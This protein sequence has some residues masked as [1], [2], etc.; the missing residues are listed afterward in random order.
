MVKL[1]STFSISLALSLLC[2]RDILAQNTYNPIAL[3]YVPNMGQFYDSRCKPRPDILY[4]ADNGATTIFLKENGLSFVIN[5]LER[6]PK[7]EPGYKD[8]D[9]PGFELIEAHH[10]WL[11]L[12][13]FPLQNCRIDLDFE[14]A[15]KPATET[16][17]PTPGYRNYYNPVCP[18]GITKVKSFQQVVYKNIYPNV[19]LLFKGTSKQ[20]FEYDIIV[21]PGGNVN[22][23][24]MK[25]SGMS[26]MEIDSGRLV[27]INNARVLKG[28]IPKIYQYIGNE[29]KA[30]AGSYIWAGKGT[31][32]TV[33][34]NV[35][36]Y[37]KKYPLIIDPW[38][39]TYC[40]GSSDDESY[41]CAIDNYGF[42]LAGGITNSNNFPV[43]KGAFQATLG[44]STDGFI[45]KLD[46]KGQRVWATYYGGSAADGVYGIITDANNN[47]IIT[48][49]TS[50][51]N[52]P[53]SLGCFQST[54]GGLEDA[55]AV[56]FDPNGVRQWGTFLGGIGN[57]EGTAINV[58]LN[59]N[60]VVTGGTASSD[61]PVSNNAYQH[62]YT[63]SSGSCKHL[64]IGD[65]MGG[66]AFLTKFDPNGN[67]LW[68][69]YLGGSG[70]DA[71][72]GVACDANGNV[73]IGGTT[74]STDFPIS[75]NAFQ[76]QPDDG[77]ITEFDS[78]GYLL[79]STYYGAWIGGCA[80][81][82]S[83]NVI[84]G[85]YSK[86][87][88]T[89][90]GVYQTSFTTGFGFAAKF[91]S[92]GNRIWATFNNSDI[93][94][95]GDYAVAVDA[96]NNVYL[97]DDE[98]P[99]QNIGPACGFQPHY[100]N[101]R[102]C[103]YVVKL[104]SL[105]RYA[106]STYLCGTVYDEHEY[107]AANLAVKGGRMAIAGYTSGGIP[108]TP[109]AFQTTFPGSAYSP[110]V[111]NVCSFSCGDTTPPNLN[112]NSIIIKSDT[113]L[114]YYS[115]TSHAVASCD[116]NG[117]TFNWYFPGGTPA[118]ATGPIISGVL[119][120]STGT[121]TVKLVYN[122]CTTD[123]FSQSF[124]VNTSFHDSIAIQNPQ[125]C[126]QKGSA[127]ALPSGGIPPY[128]YWWSNG[129][130]TASVTGLGSGSYRCAITAA[131]GCTD[132]TLFTIYSPRSPA[133]ITKPKY[134]TGVCNGKGVQLLAT[135]GTNFRWSPKGSLSCNVC[136]N[137]VATPTITTDYTVTGTDSVGC[138]D[139]AFIEVLVD[140]IPYFK[141]TAT[142]VT[143]GGYTLLQ[144]PNYANITWRWSPGKN[145]SDSLSNE[146]EATPQDTTTY[147]L[148]AYNS[149]CSWLSTV[150]VSPVNNSFPLMVT[151][152]PDTV[153]QG[154]VIQLNATSPHHIVSYS[155]VPSGGLSCNSCANPT[156][157]TSELYLQSNTYTVA[158]AAKD[159]VG[160]EVKDTLQLFI[161]QG[162]IYEN[163]IL[164]CLDSTITLKIHSDSTY[165]WSNGDTT[166]SIT[167]TPRNS[168]YLDVIIDSIGCSDTINYFIIVDAGPQVVLTAAKDTICSG[169]STVIVGLSNDVSE[170]RWSPSNT[171]SC[172][173]CNN[174][175]AT[176]NT[177]TAYTVLAYDQYGCLTKDSITLHIVP[178]NTDTVH[179]TICEATPEPI[180]ITDGNIY[181][182]STGA[183][184]SSINIDLTRDSIFYVSVT[185]NGG[186]SDTTF[187][188]VHPE[189][190]E[191]GLSASPDS[192]C[193]GKDVNL[194]ATGA[195]VVGWTWK[196]FNLLNCY[197][198]PDPSA[199]E[200]L[201]TTDFVVTGTDSLGC[202][203]SDSV[204]V[205]II[206]LPN[207]NVTASSYHIC[208][209]DSVLL[210]A[211]GG[212]AYIWNTGQ[213]T[214]AVWFKPDKD[215]I[216]GVRVLVG[217]CADSIL[218]EV[219]VYPP[220]PMTL[221]I[222]SD[223][224]CPGQSALL[225][226]GGGSSYHWS[227]GDTTS[228]ITVSPALSATYTVQIN[229]GECTEDTIASVI[230]I[231]L[232]PVNI[233]AP[234]SI[235]IGAT[236]TLN[237]SGWLTYLWS[238]NATSSSIMVN[239]VNTTTYTVT[240][241]FSRCSKD[242]VIT[243]YVK[244]VNGAISYDSVICP[245]SVVH[246][247]ALGGST[248][249]WSTGSIA[250]NIAIPGNSNKDT[251]FYVV[252]TNQGCA[253]TV[254]GEVHYSNVILIHVCCDTII[255][256]GTSAYLT[257]FG[258]TYYSW[259]PV[260][261][262]NCDTCSSVIANPDVTT[263]YSVT[264]SDTNGCIGV[265]EVTVTV[266]AP[267]NNFIIPNV[268]TPNGDGINDDF[269]IKASETKDYTII[270]YDRWGKTMFTNN[271]PD[272]YWTGANP[273]GDNAPDGVYFYII[274]YTCS[275]KGYSK[276]GFVQIIR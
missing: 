31:N 108:T 8:D 116:S 253:D 120:H 232:P 109:G 247:T 272:I 233:N 68:S 200:L 1:H 34:F 46:S 132:T 249:L 69:T 106:C 181:L 202:K 86:D 263:T 15:L 149:F 115:F 151:A 103:L 157:T 184:S 56:K 114:G 191:V 80:I 134:D 57:D 37:D 167:I 168:E 25:F 90:P 243:I 65:A 29:E 244:A 47:V 74:T 128:T 262:L 38:F 117:A 62:V 67:L 197:Y 79:W 137:P 257:A 189:R 183:T 231:P 138:P 76:S 18:D 155:W 43:S 258:A 126:N 175:I 145:L 201:S 28:H 21:N 105:G 176:V 190:P 33:K 119:Y 216:F 276:K 235:C 125:N 130:T 223:S 153:C 96:G 185:Y 218:R 198:C 22:N 236:A 58:D 204:L 24:I 42:T 215:S 174:P 110:F 193:F 269:V 121:Y 6:N 124:T 275:G 133:F 274:K 140:T 165:R 83:N 129:A 170:W 75:N 163:N 39:G 179:V 91:N 139:S 81:D 254:K 178:A 45:I 70:C 229:N 63:G 102:E 265:S 203:N 89:T 101:S 166:N 268:F 251:A 19:D 59:N 64:I 180:F 222:N 50:S 87:M 205:S 199:I 225:S 227:T 92:A 36:N 195:T 209:G 118:S 213:T 40:G 196:Q 259:T 95:A 161:N 35:G 112:V 177:Q 60:V 171:L 12:R 44:G 10:H 239:P 150:I 135:A 122:A 214:S 188:K 158:F 100:S 52:F 99:P 111:F 72:Y 51:V 77:F 245:G 104:D 270:I 264:G 26:K 182:W 208:N 84:I 241:H 154:R 113:C 17:I 7:L 98:E 207:G 9:P 41:D 162:Q 143:C 261:G 206:P 142:P 146:T 78:T 141:I 228:S 255:D 234:D 88:T 221:T 94:E 3:E 186:C 266:A 271:S 82:K 240:A 147:T 252:V 144:A 27:L 230:V 159:S 217:G 250:S 54:I 32:E 194:Y 85:G 97:E 246:I 248:Y 4:V 238:N 93:S 11:K 13:D 53:V 14:G 2:Y 160:C 242:T 30:I 173:S 164:I 172:D 220:F 16:R 224:I 152:N 260:T 211:S 212:K 219:S 71:S 148:T 127:E 187:L 5:N 73:A 107:V 210:T 131:N 156:L 237:A 49:N 23:V 61:F 192:I 226:A 66:D 123:S 20:G 256:G 273:D 169:S 267:C 136:P 48:G 55:F